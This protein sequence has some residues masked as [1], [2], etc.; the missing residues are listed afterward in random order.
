M[1]VRNLTN[2]LV[3]LF[4]DDDELEQMYLS[5][6]HDHCL[7]CH[8]PISDSNAYLDFRVCPFCRFHYTLSARERIEL[9]ADR[10]TFREHNRYV[11]SVAPLAF[12]N[13][14]TYDDQITQSQDRTG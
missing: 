7:Y 11:R 1:P 14:T 4:S 2:F 12:S 6:V 3:H 8:E 13:R 10:R 5:A 9:L